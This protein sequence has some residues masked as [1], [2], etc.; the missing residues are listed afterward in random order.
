MIHS[1]HSNTQAMNLQHPIYLYLWVA[2]HVLLIAVAI[3]MFRKGLLKE[4]PIFFSYLLF[5]FLQFSVLCAIYF[6]LLKISPGLYSK[7]DL[8]GRVGST[9]LHFGIL[10]ELFES[11]VT[12][13]ASLRQTTARMLKW[14]T[15]S[16]VVLASAFIAF[17]YYNSLGHRLLPPYAS[18]EA[19]NIAQCLLLVL[20]FLWYRFL[21]LRMPT[22]VFGIALGLG[23]TASLDP[24]IEAWKDS[25]AM[26]SSL[27]PDF[28]QMAAYHCSVVLWLYFALARE[29]VTSQ[30]GTSSLLEI[31]EAAADMG[32]IVR[33]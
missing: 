14:V 16:L 24:L 13:N 3:A 33:L 11:P 21:D 5:E 18:L 32:R 1:F 30:S 2:P 22:F 27:V 26:G 19:L 8:C 20:V 23:L 17:Q 29:K 12:H 15:G 10:Q 31:R 9:V 28:L 4:F 25:A 7:I 6:H